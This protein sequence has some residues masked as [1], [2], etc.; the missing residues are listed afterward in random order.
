MTT[1]EFI[2]SHKLIAIVRLDSYERAVETAGALAAGGVRILEFTLTGRG[3]IEAVTRTRKALGDA[4]CVGI[5][6]VLGAEAAR[7]AIAGGAQF[8][9]TPA[10]RKAVIGACVK[11]GVPVACGGFTPTELL[12]AHEA[13]SALVKLFP[14]RLGGPAYVKDVLAPLP[15]LRLVPTGG[16]GAENARAYLEAGA[17]ALGIGGNLVSN[18][19]VAA[20]RFDEMTATARAC[21]AALE[22][23]R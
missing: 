5:G 11:A 15:F 22:P 20:G 16:V 10:V 17:S 14:A 13:G 1:L 6:T 18:K 19:L 2:L 8:V 9:V 7:D 12:D 4:V 3:A 23:A 21:V